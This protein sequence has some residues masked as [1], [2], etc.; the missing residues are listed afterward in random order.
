MQ[1]EK[2]LDVARRLAKTGNPEDCRSAISRAYYAA[3]NVAQRMGFPKPSGNH[4]NTLQRRLLNSGDSEITRLGSEL[5]DFCEQ[6]NR[7]DYQMDHKPSESQ[8][9]ADAAVLR[10]EEAIK[11]LNTC[12]I[13]S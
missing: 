3:F 2:F 8:A 11:A 13:Y 12:L 5:A 7:A 6:R 1:P 10:A 4:H 9:N